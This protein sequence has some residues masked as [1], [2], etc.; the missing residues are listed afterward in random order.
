MRGQEEIAF[1]PPFDGLPPDQATLSRRGF[2]ASCATLALCVSGCHS[3]TRQTRFAHAL[4]TDPP[5]HAYRAILLGIIR[6]VL[7]FEHPQFPALSPADVFARL[8]SNFPIDD[9]SRF[10][11][12]QRGLVMFD[13]VAL[14]PH[15]FAPLID[16]EDAEGL[17]RSWVAR[18]VAD[19]ERRYLAFREARAPQADEFTELSLPAQRA[20]LTL[21][22]QSGFVVRRQFARS[23][24]T[25]TT[26]TAYTMRPLEDAIGYRGP[27]LGDPRGSS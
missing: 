14:F 20:Y 11:T 10:L 13:Q 27:L 24:K 15:Q 26:I 17:D 12:L 3:W 8:T 1:S 6:A 25:L 7:P 22:L 2:V 16:A 19:D 18:S 21:W 5:P 9:E 23:V 4:V